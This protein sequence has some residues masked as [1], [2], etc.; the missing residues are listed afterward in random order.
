MHVPCTPCSSAQ[1]GILQEHLEA[2]QRRAEAALAS[3]TLDERLVLQAQ[4]AQQ[5]KALRKAQVR[6]GGA[7]AGAGVPHVQ[8]EGCHGLLALLG[9]AVAQ[10]V[11]AGVP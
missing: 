11:A 9:W 10:Q 8:T 4:Q 5:A 7:G 6:G 3:A 2:A 1:E